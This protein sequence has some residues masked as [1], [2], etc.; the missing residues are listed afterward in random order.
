MSW[1]GVAVTKWRQRF[2][3]DHKLNYYSMSELAERFG[4]SRKTAHSD[5]TCGG[6][7]PRSEAFV[8]E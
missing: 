3:D 1:R 8:V 7:N 4:I 2:L 5:L 6:R